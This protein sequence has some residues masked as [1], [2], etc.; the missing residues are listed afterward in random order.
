[1]CI[2]DRALVEYAIDMQNR[3]CVLDLTGS[4]RRLQTFVSLSIGSSEPPETC[5]WD[6]MDDIVSD[7]DR[8]CCGG[9]VCDGSN[10]PTEC[11]PGCAV[12]IHEFHVSDKTSCVLHGHQL[13][14]VSLTSGHRAFCSG[15]MWR[16]S[17]EDFRRRGRKAGRLHC[18]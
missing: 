15:G 3:G 18:I 13:I 4:G 2:R 11:N 14:S 5:P 12:A 9:G 1:M 8:V 17:R 7:I 6:D 16:N 10:P